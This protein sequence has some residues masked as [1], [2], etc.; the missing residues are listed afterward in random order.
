VLWQVLLV[1]PALQ[2]Q[3]ELRQ[4]HAWSWCMQ[5]P[6]LAPQPRTM[7]PHGVPTTDIGATVLMSTLHATH[8]TVSTVAYMCAQ[9]WIMQS[10]PLS[11][12]TNCADT[13]S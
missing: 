10:R 2:L 13:A 4:L 5:V 1:W 11:R 3:R 6:C 7:R 9:W 8:S 12:S